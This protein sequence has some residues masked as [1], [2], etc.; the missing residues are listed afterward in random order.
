MI[1]NSWGGG[2]QDLWYRDIVTAWVAAGM[3][4][5]FANGNSGPSCGTAGSPGDYA[6]SYAVGAH[7]STGGIA[8]FSS[9]GSATGLV[10][11]DIAAPGVGVRSSVP[12]NTYSTL[13]GTSMAAPHVAGAVALMWSAAPSLVSDVARTREILDETAVDVADLTCGGTEA[14]N[15]VWGEGKLDALN[16]VLSS[17]RGPVGTFSGVVVDRATGAPVGGARVTSVGADPFPRIVRTSAAGAFSQVLPIGTLQVQVT[18]F[19]YAVTSTEAVVVENGTTVVEISLAPLPRHTISGTVLD[20]AAAPIPGASVSLTGVPIP[21]VTTDATGSF[22]LTAIPDGDYDVAASAGPCLAGASKEVQLDADTTV[23]F[24]LTV[25][26]DGFGYFCQ[27]QTPAY[28]D[29]GT[30]VPLTGSDTVLAVTL[31]FPFSFYGKSYATARVSANGL[32]G[33]FQGTSSWINGPIPDPAVPNGTIFAFWDDLYVDSQSSVR[34]ATLGAEP[35]RRFVIEWRNVRW[36]DYQTRFDFEAILDQRGGILLQYR[37]L[38]ADPLPRGSSATIGIEN[39]TGTTGLAYSYNQPA[40]TGTAAAV[41]FEAAGAAGNVAPDAVD[42]LA[43]TIAGRAVTFPVLGNDVDPEGGTLDVTGVSDPPHGTAVLRDDDTISFVPDFGFSGTEVFTYDLADGLGGTDRASISVTIGPLATDD[44]AIT[45][46]DT[47]GTVQVLANDL[48]PQSGTL[49]VYAVSTPA[50]GT[51]AILAGGAV[52]YT[53]RPDFNG[54]DAFT[55]NVRDG[56]GGFDQGSVTI[57]VSAVNDPPSPFNDY[58]EAPQDGETT[59]AVL[60]NDTDV[61]GDVLQVVTVSDPPHGTATLTAAQTITFRPDPGFIGPQ[62]FSYDVSDGRGGG[63]GADITIMV[64]PAIVTTTTSTP[65]TTTTPT[66]TTTTSTTSTSTTSTSTTSTSTTSTSTTTSTTLPAPSP[67]GLYH[68]LAPARILDTRNGTGG[69]TSPVGPDSAVS[70]AVTGVGGVPATGVNAVVLN[71]TVTQPTAQ[72]FLSIYPSGTARPL[73]SNLNFLANQTIPNLVVA[74]VGA[75]GKVDL[76]NYVGSSHVIFDVVGWYGAESAAAGGRYN[77][78]PPSRILDTRTGNGG[79]SAPVGPGGT[80]SATVAG[81]GGVPLTGV[82][83]VVLNVTV[84][85]PTA[86]GF[87]T[88]FPSGTAWPLASNLNFLPNQTIP[89]LVVAKVGAD[90]KVAVYNYAGSSHVIFDI[91]G[92]YGVAGGAAGSRLTPLT[93]SR[94]LDTRTGNGGFSTPVPAGGTISPTVAGVGGVPATGVDAVVLNVTVTQPT[95]E[96]F[97]TVFPSGGARPLASN[98]NFLANQTIPNLVVAKVG[99]DGK[100]SVYNHAGA[101]HVIFDVV[102]W[103]S[104]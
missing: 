57:N 93:P 73:A 86:Q 36:H 80:I 48:N 27:E 92:W 43:A 69:F 103:Y 47:P 5:V 68:P 39:E 2:P 72:G 28:I 94:I 45:A 64:W 99:A 49:E 89:N 9:R 26:Q 90:G 102:G 54:S 70:V 30:V 23:D 8:S 77:P 46:E 33:L 84:T 1:N 3:F 51:A 38:A 59:V 19:G 42:D 21:P 101:S 87:L 32:V 7:S 65:T 56:L 60:A 12:G 34:T 53:P 15:G 63:G 67:S 25:R 82:D 24:V 74:K 62:T 104:S 29:A 55:Y 6:E 37:R 16:A 10:K 81:V 44:T 17:P 18:A 95:A 11:P 97:L 83:A 66:S 61:D 78:L 14:D 98:L 4:P 40:L 31:P 71:V 76:Y 88:V 79:F 13:N 58:A 75:G 22:R 96:S 100:V 41:R 35:N 85:Q 20:S 50:R 52:A 91:V